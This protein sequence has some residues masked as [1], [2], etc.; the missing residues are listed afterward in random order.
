M[1]NTSPS[2][3]SETKSEVRTEDDL[4]TVPLVKSGTKTFKW[5]P[6]RFIAEDGGFCHGLNNAQLT[7]VY[8]DSTN[9]PTCNA[10]F[11]AIRE[12]G[13]RRGNFDCVIHLKGDN[14][15]DVSQVRFGNAEMPCKDSSSLSLGPVRV[16]PGL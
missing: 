7:L 11:T 12:E 4:L 15:A 1:D 14:G 2:M 13:G 9:P 6:I 3:S 16:Q 10:N 8:D 5:P